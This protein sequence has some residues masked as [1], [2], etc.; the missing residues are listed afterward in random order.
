MCTEGQSQIR[1]L[2]PTT[3][4]GPTLKRG[5][6]AN[7]SC[8]QV[9]VLFSTRMEGFHALHGIFRTTS[10]RATSSVQLPRLH[11]FWRTPSALAPSAP[12][13]LLITLSETGTW[14][15]CA[16]GLLRTR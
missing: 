8:E 10:L 14:C 16:T 6:Y 2:S 1:S 13:G 11:K 5:T 4:T 15:D 7:A 12:I 3:V 9:D